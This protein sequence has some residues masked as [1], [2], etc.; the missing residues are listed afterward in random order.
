VAEAVTPDIVMMDL[1]EVTF[2]GSSG[3]RI[4]MSTH[5]HC[6]VQNTPMHVLDPAPSVQRVME[7]LG[8]DRL[9]TVNS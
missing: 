8:L 7:L 3:L 2:M 6:K 1:S 5:Q 4:L 9:F